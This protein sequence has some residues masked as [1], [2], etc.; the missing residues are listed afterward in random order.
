MSQNKTQ[1]VA[2]HKMLRTKASESFPAFW[3]RKHHTRYPDAAVSRMR[4]GRQLQLHSVSARGRERPIAEQREHMRLISR[5][6][7]SKAK[8]LQA[9]VRHS[10]SPFQGSCSFSSPRGIGSHSLGGN[11]PITEGK[12]NE[13]SITQTSSGHVLLPVLTSETYFAF[14]CSKQSFTDTHVQNDSLFSSAE[15]YIP[16]F[17]HDGLSYRR[18]PSGPMV[19]EGVSALSGLAQVGPVTAHALESKNYPNGFVSVEA[20][21]LPNTGCPYAH[22]ACQTSSDNRFVCLGGHARRED[23]GWQVESPAAIYAHK[24]SVDAG[25]S[26]N[27]QTFSP[28]SKE[29]PRSREDREYGSSGVCQSPGRAAF[30]SGTHAGTQTDF[31]E[32]CLTDFVA[33]RESNAGSVCVTSECVV[34]SVLLAAQSECHSG[35]RRLSTR[36]D[37]HTV[38]R[39]PTDNVNLPNSSQSKR[40]RSDC[41]LRGSTWAGQA[42]ADG[43]H[44]ASPGQPLAP[45]TAQVST[46]LGRGGD[47]SSTPGAPSPLGLTREWFNLSATGLPPNVIKTIQSARAPSTRSLYG[48][49]WGVFEQW[50][51]DKLETPFQC[52][53]G[54]ILSFL[55]DLIDKGRSFSTVKVYLA[56]IAS[57]HVGFEGKTVGQHPLVCRFMK[58]A[59]RLLPVSKPLSP[60]WDLSLVLEALSAA[61][62]EP[63]D[64][65]DFKILSFKTA[66]LLALASAKRVSEIH[67]FSVHSSCMQFSQGDTKICLRPNPVFIPKVIQPC[68]PLELQAFYPP[69]FTSHNQQRLNALCPVRA[70][71]IYVDKSKSFRKSDQL[72][73][74]WAKPYTGRAITKQRLSHWISEAIA[75]AYTSKGLAVP[76]G[77]RAHSTRGIATSW[78][79][80]SGLSIQEVC[81][82]ASW[83]SPH[84]FTRFYKLDITAPTIAHAV[85]SAGSGNTQSPL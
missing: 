16:T 21:A 19:H 84:T 25:G 40:E 78:A 81:A 48:Y 77:I 1:N 9:A 61:P 30:P 52:S 12:S 49:K 56:A 22:S 36:M 41:S 69:P 66:L 26:A 38:L 67:A 68:L 42:L 53:V 70:L 55:Q 24:L 57:C 23:S 44:A 29:M 34:P 28:C 74:S 82:A 15:A 73:V 4:S 75:L 27:T 33:L 11:F 10:A 7:Q 17:G 37:A 71:R 45:P 20:R 35:G 58:G 6:A 79:V 64:Q 13:S 72:F 59:R 39:V 83:S 18:C 32:Q 5:G 46:D 8:C 14:T 60:S 54:I 63:L 51:S 85:L 2:K 31:M 80:F 3:A 43:S 50:C 62:F 76:P 47:V 65:V